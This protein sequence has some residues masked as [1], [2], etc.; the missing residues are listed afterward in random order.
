MEVTF[1]YFMPLIVFLLVFIV[2][3]ALLAKT[4]I[5]GSNA[6]VHMFISFLVSVIFIASPSLTDL[7]KLAIPWVIVFTIILICILILV[8]SIGNLDKIVKNPKIAMIIVVVI[9]VI[10]LVSAI[11]VFGPIIRPY[12]PTATSETGGVPE[13][14]Q[15]KHVLFSPGILGMI[16]LLI[17]AAIAS[18]IITKK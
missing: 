4:K 14:L 15:V 13:L 2:I 9:I 3:Y 8:A 1:A 6:F 16:V 18:W 17:I 11:N 5:L 7:T 10:F 12:L